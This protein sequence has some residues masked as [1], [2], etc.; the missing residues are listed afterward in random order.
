MKV[1][2]R[3]SA[4]EYKEPG[5]LK[6]PMR[7]SLNRRVLIFR[8]EPELSKTCFLFLIWTCSL[9]YIPASSHVWA[10]LGR[11]PAVAVPS[12][13]IPPPRGELLA[14]DEVVIIA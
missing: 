1:D 12:V 13:D 2:P 4:G 14:V 9:V 3:R 8:M 6:N 7:N 10:D 11:V 5:L